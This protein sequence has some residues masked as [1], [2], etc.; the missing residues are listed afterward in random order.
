MNESNVVEYRYEQVAAKITQLIHHGT[1]RPGERIPSVRRISRQEKVSVSTALQA[2]FLL[3]D[4]GL[5]EARPQSGFYVRLQSRRL[6]AEPRIIFPPQAATRVG[7]GDLVSNILKAG[8]NPGIV[9]LGMA[10]SSPDLFPTAKLHRVLASVA[11]REGIEVNRYD[12]APGYPELRHQIARRSLDWGC[13]LSG[14][15]IVVTAGCTDALN[16][17]LRAVAGPGDV[18]AVES[19]TY[20]VL[21]MILEALQMKAIEIPTYPRDGVCLDELE[22]ALD[23][24][25]VKACL[26]MPNFH[27]PM[28]SCIPDEK[29]KR[30]VDLLAQREI[31]L[32]EDDIYGDV[33]FGAA[34][35]KVAKAF[36]RKGLVLLCSSF[37][38]T[39]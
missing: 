20:F 32:I 3:E 11:R 4:R 29:K 27:N 2:Y 9:P 15:D 7:I 1:L 37:S 10:A 17:C 19:P 30:L 36:D 23:R 33:Y 5:I 39:L 18:I 13:S 22:A 38:K 16:L 34:R 14:D 8:R 26:F 12:L 21:L 31:P 24:R 35:P 25:K 6:P 28:G